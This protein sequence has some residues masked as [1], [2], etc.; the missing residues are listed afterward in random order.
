VPQQRATVTRDKLIHT[1]T[2]LIRRKGFVAT[3]IEDVC[4][5]A[6][7]TK[8][9]FFHH[10]KTK[11]HLAEGC[12][13]AWGQALADTLKKAPFQ[14]AATPKK[15]ALGSMEFFIKVF[16]DP[17]TLKSCLV[18]TTIQETSE[19]HLQLREASH[20]CFTRLKDFFKTMLDEA[21]D[22]R[23][24]RVDTASLADL[25]ISAIQGSLIVYKASRDPSVIRKNLQHVKQ[26][27]AGYLPE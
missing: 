20:Q 16:D 8:G 19:T 13:V 14:K 23:K 17:N 25:W 6:G 12:L 9:A 2:D 3:R 24:P 10:F 21:C 7:V 18:G 15:R 1:A 11:E 5:L 4:D 26:Y 27:I 22:Q